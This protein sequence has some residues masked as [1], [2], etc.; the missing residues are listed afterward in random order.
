V[1][2]LH[3]VKVFFGI[4]CS[5]HYFALFFPFKVDTESQMLFKSSA[6][7]YKFLWGLH[8]ALLKSAVLWSILTEND[9]PWSMTLWHCLCGVIDHG[10]AREFTILWLIPAVND[11]AEIKS[12]FQ[13][14][15]NTKPCVKGLIRKSGPYCI[16][17]CDWVMEKTAGRK[18][19]GTVSF[20]G[21]PLGQNERQWSNRES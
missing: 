15:V 11:P 16:N 4:F 21:R 12:N 5:W 7:P 1:L 18:S 14:L 10:N 19:L 2:F 8:M 13:Y 6:C 20:R 17:R 9:H 3:K